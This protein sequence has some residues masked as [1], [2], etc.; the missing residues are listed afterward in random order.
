VNRLG[1]IANGLNLR[2][3]WLILVGAAGLAI[4]WWHANLTE[5]YVTIFSCLILYSLRLIQYRLEIDPSASNLTPVTKVVAAA[6]EQT[7]ALMLR[8]Q[9]LALKLNDPTH[10]KN[11]NQIK[12][13]LIEID[14]ALRALGFIAV[15]PE[16]TTTV[17]DRISAA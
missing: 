13:E 1:S 17:V 12:L 10:T 14:D 4:A 16:S 15:N 6:E 9:A 8:R 2:L 5:A 11:R 3:R 7:L